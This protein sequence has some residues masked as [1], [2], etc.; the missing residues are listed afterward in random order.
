[1]PP[2]GDQCIFCQLM[3]NPE[4][5]NIIAETDNF[6]VWHEYPEPRAKGQA[7]IVPKEHTESILDL[8]PG[9]Y[10]EAMTLVRKIMGKAKNSIEADGMTVVIPESETG[11]QMLDHMYI[12]IF[13]RFE[14]DEN[15]GTPAS[16]LFPQ[17]EMAEDEIKETAEAMSSHEINFGE[18]KTAHPESQRFKDEGKAQNE[19]EQASSEEKEKESE[20]EDEDLESQHEGKSFE[21]K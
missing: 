9:K 16:A 5:L 18:P 10:Q 14:E 6:Y 17:I 4:Q 13:P 7:N 2:Q 3:E 20:E 12:Q 8:D 11:G 21:W 15:A 1:M 19:E